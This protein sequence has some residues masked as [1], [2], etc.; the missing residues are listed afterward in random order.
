MRRSHRCPTTKGAHRSTH[1]RA[2][3]HGGPPDEVPRD[4]PN[5]ADLQVRGP[6][7]RADA[8]QPRDP[9]GRAAQPLSDPVQQ[10]L[11]LPGRNSHASGSHEEAA[12]GGSSQRKGIQFPG[13]DQ[14]V[15]GCE[16]RRSRRRARPPRREGASKPFG[17]RA[18]DG[19]CTAGQASG[20]VAAKPT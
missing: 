4:T 14:S 15:P 12:P 1:L 17:C 10:R 13:C 8:L 7:L 18:A 6:P 5:G 20:P 19:L 11:L 9:G 2:D 16:D 3:L